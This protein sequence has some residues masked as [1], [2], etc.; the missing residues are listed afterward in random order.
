MIGWGL[1]S[2]VAAATRPLPW[3]VPVDESPGYYQGSLRDRVCS[4]AARLGCNH[5]CIG[6]CGHDGNGAQELRRL[7]RR[8]CSRG[9]STTRGSLVGLD[10]EDAQVLT[11]RHQGSKARRRERRMAH[12]STRKTSRVSSSVFICAHLW[13]QLFPGASAA[14]D[15]RADAARFSHEKKPLDDC[16]RAFL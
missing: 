11:R 10:G 13:L 3:Y 2:V 15:P 8:K 7:R 6:R 12:K 16:R 14:H 1:N 9:E 5:R 4:S